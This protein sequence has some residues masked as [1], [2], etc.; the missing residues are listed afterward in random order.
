MNG[1]DFLERALGVG[2]WGLVQIR[3]PGQQWIGQLKQEAG[4]TTEEE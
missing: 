3:K 4:R 1:L 2:G